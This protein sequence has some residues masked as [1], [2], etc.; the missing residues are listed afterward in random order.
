MNNRYTNERME[1]TAVC[2][3]LIDR[4]QMRMAVQ[5]ECA[6]REYNPWILDGMLRT[7]II[8]DCFKLLDPSG[9]LFRQLE[10]DVTTHME[11]IPDSEAHTI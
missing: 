1:L 5:M 10:C 3:W 4:G 2:N 8:R 7:D 9:L 11:I 6:F